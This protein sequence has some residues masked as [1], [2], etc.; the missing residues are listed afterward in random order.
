MNLNKLIVALISLTLMSCTGIQTRTSTAKD[1]KIYYSSTGFALIY[2]DSFYQNKVV[3]KKIN[4]D[5]ILLLHKSL[6]TNTA[7]R[8]TNLKNS[9]SID[10]KVYSLRC[11]GSSNLMYIFSNYGV[12]ALIK[13]PSKCLCQ[14]L[15]L[16][17]FSLLKQL[18]CL[19]CFLHW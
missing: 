4:N 5:K 8:I 9:K 7:V 1:E 3:N 17:H 2:K 13:M 19:T 10:T 15:Y 16:V 11:Y 6:K 12:I 18:I 14:F